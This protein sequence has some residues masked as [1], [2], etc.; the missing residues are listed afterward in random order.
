MALGRFVTDLT[1]HLAPGTR[2]LTNSSEEEFR[3]ATLRWSDIN[4]K[5]PGAIIKVT[6]ELDAVTIASPMTVSQVV[7]NTDKCNDG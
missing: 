3:D 6:S 2:I 1:E 4:A 5:V 7:P